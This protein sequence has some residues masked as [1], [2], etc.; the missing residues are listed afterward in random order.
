VRPCGLLLLVLAAACAQTAPAPAAAAASAPAPAVPEAALQEALR[1]LDAA[2]SLRRH[3]EQWEQVRPVAEEV[4]AE[5]AALQPPDARVAAAMDAAHALVDWQALTEASWSLADADIEAWRLAQG[6]AANAL[7]RQLEAAAGRV[8][9]TSVLRA[10]ILLDTA[11]PADAAAELKGALLAF[12]THF[13]LHQL[14]REHRDRL[15]EPE[16]LAAVAEHVAA[17]HADARVEALITAG[18]LRLAAGLRAEAAGSEALALEENERGIKDLTAAQSGASRSDWALVATLSDLLVN[19][20]ALHLQR[21]QDRLADGVDAMRQDLLAAERLYGDALALRDD[22]ADARAGCA[23]AADLYYQAGDMPGARDAFARLAE[24]F[25]DAEW[26]NNAAFLARETEEYERSYAA[27]ERC[28]AL[29][30]DNARYVNDTGLILLYHLERELPHAEELFRRAIE[31]GKAACENPFS[32]DAARE[33]N[34]VA[35][36]DAMLNLALLMARDGRLDQA[37]AL[38]AELLA[39]APDRPDAQQLRADI[40]AARAQDPSPGAK[41]AASRSP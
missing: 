24:R 37:A 27:Y 31:L 18:A 26:W 7:L 25:D 4:V 32:D 21:A 34:F 13:E 41:R 11:R 12:P 19:S 10:A 2:I 35:Y 16:A 15:P 36:T 20:A 5:L 30:P 39:L 3:P 23:A 33:A 14:L 29:E 6:A 1:N 9:Q 8:P 22:D 28:I 40:E 38:V 17:T